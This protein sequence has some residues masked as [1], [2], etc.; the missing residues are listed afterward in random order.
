MVDPLRGIVDPLRGIV[1]PLRGMV[2]PLRGMVDPLRG[3]VDPLRGI[4]DPLRGI[5][6][7][8]RGMV[9]PLRGM[10][11]PLRGIV[12]PLR[13]KVEPL[14]EI[15]ASYRGT[16]RLFLLGGGVGARIRGARRFAGLRRA[17][18]GRWDRRTVRMESVQPGLKSQ[19]G[20]R[21]TSCR[22][23]SL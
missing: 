12:D 1:D 11:D 4:V 2:D 19:A 22:P 21:S 9:E 5:V 17:Q 7:P 8:L 15:E 14:R 13:I 6:D 18:S 23:R 10:V 3:M 20:D 16:A